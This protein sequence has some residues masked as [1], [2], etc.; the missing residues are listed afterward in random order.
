MRA[1]YP[2]LLAIFGLITLAKPARAAR[3]TP[4]PVLKQF[5]D[6]YGMV[7]AE[8]IS[9]PKQPSDKKEA[10]VEGTYDV[11]FRVVKVVA[12]TVGAHPRLRLKADDEFDATVGV[13][14]GEP[15][16]QYDQSPFPKGAR[17]Y[18]TIRPSDPKT[19]FE[20]ALGAGAAL[21]VPR[22][23][24]H[25]DACYARLRTVAALPFDRRWD[26]VLSIAADAKADHDVR[27]HALGYLGRYF[28]ANGL[29]G[30]QY[31][32]RASDRLWAMWRGP[33]SAFAEDDLLQSLDYAL[34]NFAWEEFDKSA[35]RRHK[36]I[37]RIFAPPAPGMAN[38]P[39]MLE[40]RE[41]LTYMLPRFAADNQVEVGS[42]II[43]EL[44]TG[45]WPPTFRNHLSS[46]L[47]Q[48]YL[49]SPLPE[50]AWEPALQEAF[51][52]LATDLTNSMDFRLIAATL[53]DAA[54]MQIKPLGDAGV[55]RHFY[56]QE[57][58][59]KLLTE[60]IPG[61][62]ARAKPD[63]PDQSALAAQELEE[64]LANQKSGAA[65]K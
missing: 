55:R 28:V 54:T 47:L 18:L 34:A 63:D 26:E 14:Y 29:P 31:V 16:E 27:A 33:A 9:T 25:S 43:T 42:R 50:P 59:Q 32:R 58:N 19:T 53:T 20:H 60:R 52:H 17:F 13:G 65:K 46:L 21:S 64:A 1:V 7:A 48:I 12:E 62:R 2:T 11:K 39:A 6:G 57:A 23:D 49:E 30:E 3:G 36:W 8:V 4:D 41:A 40:R 10:S 61:L 24:D 51:S 5:E 35:E 22:F 38:D 56:L 37:E 45:G 44:R 15:V